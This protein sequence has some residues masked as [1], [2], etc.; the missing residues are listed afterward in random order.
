M[1]IRPSRLSATTIEFLRLSTVFAVDV[2]GL[3]SSI[4]FDESQAP[5]YACDSRTQLSADSF[6]PI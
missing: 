4:E 1:N 6:R 3:S 5:I 2:Y